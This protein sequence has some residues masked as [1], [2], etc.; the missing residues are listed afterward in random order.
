MAKFQMSLFYENVVIF[1][2]LF[3]RHK[4]I[5][6][7]GTSDTVRSLEIS[8]NL[9]KGSYKLLGKNYTDTS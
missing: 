1:F 8:P 3:L 7:Q 6:W 5:L 4:L 9:K 2:L